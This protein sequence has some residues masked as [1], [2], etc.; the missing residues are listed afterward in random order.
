MGELSDFD[1]QNAKAA[2]IKN[3]RTDAE[4]DTA[5]Q[6]RIGLFPQYRPRLSG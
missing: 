3:E 6:H 4:S 1:R 2:G 5:D